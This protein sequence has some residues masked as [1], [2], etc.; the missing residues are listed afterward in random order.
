MSK[1][2]QETNDE[3]EP[4]D[5]SENESTT[6]ASAS[7]IN[8]SDIFEN[9]EESKLSLLREAIKAS[10]DSSSTLPTLDEDVSFN[11]YMDHNRDKIDKD[12]YKDLYDPLE[13][14][15]KE[16]TNTIRKAMQHHGEQSL[17]FDH[18]QG[19]SIHID[20]SVDL[21]YEISNNL[22]IVKPEPNIGEDKAPLCL[23]L[24]LQDESGR[25][26]KAK[27]AK[28]L[29]I[30]YDESGKISHI[31]HPEPLEINGDK[32][33]Y[34]VGDKT[35]YLKIDHSTLNT[36]KAQIEINKGNAEAI[37]SA[38]NKAKKIWQILDAEPNEDIGRN[39]NTPTEGSLQNT[40]TITHTENSTIEGIENPIPKNPEQPP[41]PP[42]TKREQTV[43]TPN[44]PELPRTEKDQTRGVL[45]VL[46]NNRSL[47][48]ANKQKDRHWQEIK[49]NVS[50]AKAKNQEK[51]E[52]ERGEI[53]PPDTP[54]IK[55]NREERSL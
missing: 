19:G 2:G 36:L 25:N 42:R 1:D 28:Y 52:R 37:D 38:S 22:K 55:Q 27:D 47:E 30:N 5:L 7:N 3:F 51:R 29:F 32:C 23:S 39:E 40:N 41:P 21:K 8:L 4:E 44:S 35:Y 54:T 53:K 34:K 14:I 20:G 43:T 33:G 9:Y 11:E 50:E 26:M 49:K 15:E 10:Q 13:A 6:S 12:K 48:E 18:Q 45:H 24:P 17:E 31:S 16:E 46:L